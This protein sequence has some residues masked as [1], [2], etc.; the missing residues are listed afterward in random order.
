MK[1]KGLI[2]TV[3][4]LILLTSQIKAQ[5]QVNW[6]TFS[7]D[8]YPGTYDTNNKYLGGTDLMYLVNHKGKL[9][10][11][12]S[13]WN[14]NPGSDPTPGPQILYKESSSSNWT[15][16]TSMGTGYLRTDAF[17]S[18]VFTED[19]FGNPLPQPDTLLLASFSDLTAPY[20]IC[21]WVRDDLNNTWIKTVVY[22]NVSS[23]NNSYIRH[24]YLYEDKVTGIQHI[25]VAG[26][27]A[28]IRGAYNTAL[29]GKLEW[30]S[31]EITGP[32]RMLSST[33]CNNDYYVAFG[34]DGNLTNQGGLFRRND[35]A[36]PTWSFIY[37]WPDTN[38][39]NGKETSFRGMTAVKDP[40]G[41][42]HQVIVGFP[43]NM[44][45]S[46]RI[47]PV[48]NTQI[49]EV[50]WRS[51]FRNLWGFPT[52]TDFNYA[53]YNNMVELIAPDNGDTCLLAGVWLTYP[54][55]Y[56]TVNRNNSWYLVRRPN[57]NWHYGQVIDSLN[58]IPAGTGLQATRTIIKSPFYDEP[59]VY[60]FGGM[61]AGGTNPVFHNTAWIYKGTLQ[62]PIT[63]IS[64]FENQLSAIVIYPNPTQNQLT[65]SNLPSSFKGFVSIYNSV[66]QLIQSEQKSGSQFFLQTGQL[67]NGIYFIQVKSETGEMTTNKFIK[68]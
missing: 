26:V 3:A 16:D 38:A 49:V 20:D 66:G 27:T 23:Q 48:N 50:N 17:Y 14:D 35:G 60:Y 21:V 47:D 58:L 32:Q 64:D 41:G 68:E 8:Y 31:I 55:A 37:E 15:V 54:D 1:Y 40:L 57:G 44:R 29:P 7:K 43:E 11:G 39:L 42:N 61:D 36:S 19:K 63:G 34:S 30:Q 53:A 18:F 33:V 22:P 6:F 12:T 67:S 45:S 46:I 24:M 13:V 62:S 25:F 10:A 4:L 59:N 65:I 52:F 51:F 28:V 56:G 2:T 5:S 9:W